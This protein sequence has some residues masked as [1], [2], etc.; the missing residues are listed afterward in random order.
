MIKVAAQ[1]SREVPSAAMQLASAKSDT[2]EPFSPCMYDHMA[3]LPLR[4]HMQ[5][6]QT[7]SRDGKS[8]G[9]SNA[10]N[11][12]GSES[13]IVARTGVWIFARASV[14]ALAWRTPEVNLPWQIEHGRSEMSFLVDYKGQHCGRYVAEF[15]TFQ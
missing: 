1:E 3:E 14:D 13:H 7:V 15:R 5:M 2:P 12:L 9:H 6:Q 11:T 4:K 10:G 8:P